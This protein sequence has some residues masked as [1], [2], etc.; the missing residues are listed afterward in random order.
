MTK[1]CKK[2]E[3]GTDNRSGLWTRII[4]WIFGHE[5]EWVGMDMYV[6]SCCGKENSK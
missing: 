2:I 1:E 3:D 6:C 4:C 5:F